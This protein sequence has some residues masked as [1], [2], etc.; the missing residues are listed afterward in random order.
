MA[1]IPVYGGASPEVI[2]AI[3]GPG[4]RGVV[5]AALGAGHV[6]GSWSEPLG[7]LA[8]E[9]P[10]VLASQ[11]GA[12][13]VFT[14]GYGYAG[15]EIDLIGARRPDYGGRADAPTRRA[16]CFPCWSAREVTGPLLRK[17]SL[18]SDG[19]DSRRPRPDA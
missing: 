5:V 9:K 7:R 4:V 18:A 14:G 11:I 8:Q 15:G 13:P 1:I 3:A 17:L 12:G 16:S 2:E 19:S 6:P 10:V